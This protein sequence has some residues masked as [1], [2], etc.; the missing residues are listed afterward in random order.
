M[1]QNSA[2]VL[3]VEDEPTVRLS[4]AVSL[5]ETGFKVYEA[6][7]ADDAMKILQKARDI[8]LVITD[9]NMPGSMDGVALAHHVRER[10]PSVAIIVTSGLTSP[11]AEALPQHANFVQ[12][13]YRVEH[14]VEIFR[15]R[16]N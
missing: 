9:I 2:T 14:L 6:A 10:Y 13:P 5:E 7:N 16:A 11:P 1:G 15:G 12:K 3:V 4:L 8:G